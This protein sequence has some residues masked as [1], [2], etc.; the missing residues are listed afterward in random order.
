MIKKYLYF[1]GGGR[2]D[3]NESMKNLLGGKGANLAEMAG[4]KNLRLPVPP[5]FTITTEVCAYYYANKH[6]Y[7]KGLK[8]EVHKS[9]KRVEELMGKKFGNVDDP[10]LVSVRSGARRSMP[11]MMET[12]LNVG[13]TTKTIPG[14]IKQSR[15]E[16][17]VYD[18]YR[19]LITMYSDVVMEKAA[20]IEPEHDEAGIRKRL[21]K[22]MNEMKKKKGMINDTDLNTEDLKKLCILFKKKIKE[23]LKKDFPDDP[24]EQLWG[25]IGAVFV[26]WN[27]KRAVS[28]RKIEDIPDEWG[29]AVNVQS[30]VFG[31]MGIDCATG[32]AF[33]RNPGNGENKFYGEYLVNAQGED[34]VA[35]LRTPAPI[36]EDSKN[37]HNKNLT[38]LEK[39]MPQLYKQL[40]EYQ[41]RLEKHYRD[42]Q[43]IEFTIEKGE[44]FM[45]Q[46]RI[47]KR[48]GPAAIKMAV[49]MVRE[50]LITP[51]IAVMRVTP[52]QIDE[53][54][55]PIIDPRDEM[56]NKPIAHGLPA[57]PGGA[58]GMIVFSANDAVAWAGGGKKVI[59]V[60][61][62]TNPEDVEGMRAAQAILTARGGMTSHAALVA[63][64]W[65]K[66]CIVGCGTIHI[67]YFKKIMT[68]DNKIYKQGDWF[69][70]NGTKGN[71]YQGCLK[72]ID[73]SSEN[74][75]LLEFLKLCDK[76]RRLKIRTNA[77][78]P[79][80]SKRARLY[81]AEGIGLFRIEHMF[82]G[83]GSDKALFLLRK[84]IVSKT[85]QERK[86]ALNELFPYM[87]MDIKRTLRVMKGLPVTI[88]LIDPPL[89]EFVPREEKQQIN[90]SKSLR[91]SF[92]EFQKRAN[93]LHENNPM[94]GHRGVRLGITYPEITEMQV[95]AIFEATAELL[96]EKV[97]VEPEIMIPVTCDVKELTH[98]VAIIRR[99]YE[100]VLKKFHF[101]KIDYLVGTMIEIPRAALTAGEMA[102]EA[103]FFSFGT[104]DLTQMGFGFSRDDMGGFLPDYLSK[105]ILANDPFQTI[106][107]NGIGELIKIGIDRGRK[108][109]KNLKIGICGEHGG[110]P[111]SITFCHQVGMDYVSCSPFRI[112][113]ARLS[114][115]QAA[116]KKG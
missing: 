95:R 3:G 108:T 10:L 110:D 72:M 57:G 96:K 106:D 42:M 15:N 62:E 43:D 79:E 28:Y 19:R 18:A 24:Y 102:R 97:K 67:D 60:R 29:T 80:D 58:S 55:H 46:C 2:A 116:L 68:V 82:Y 7:P 103:E 76:Y 78:T 13:L 39:A 20:G 109:K 4:H 17:F 49:D 66:C 113:I 104:N 63:R 59:L 74:K 53:L 23:V 41:K 37:D 84:M 6:V 1:F 73:A 35:G 36:N 38:S 48:N 52:S 9:I 25:G 98:Q 61:E 92:T 90:L 54:L 21:E 5:G 50:K 105:G 16:R 30:M 33:T 14:L 56:K 107:Q 69:T 81:G 89:H 93:L 8:E 86:I 31:N 114:A 34:V 83:E 12:V 115:A 100:E 47:G 45:L 111:T 77:D 71:L 112:P 65:G 101:K 87:K 44:L 26:S 32:V 51:E 88:R 99:V 27:G 11:G 40:F 85:E 70:L 64:G 22:I 91:I 75:L 94:M